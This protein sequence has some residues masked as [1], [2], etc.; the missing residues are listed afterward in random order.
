MQTDSPILV[1]GS[2]GK[3]GRRVAEQLRQQ[4]LAVRE[5]SRQSEIPFD[6]A[7]PATW[8][9]S[10]RGVWAAYIT[11]FPD[12]AEPAAPA[13]IRE[14]TALA[15]A[16]GLERLVLLSGRGEANAE[17]CEQIVLNSGVSA[18]CVRASWFN[19]NFDEGMLI[20]SVLSGT[21]AFPAGDVRE[22]F[23]DSDDIAD[24]VVA[25]L[26]EDGHVG[27]LYEITGPRLM[28]FAEVADELARVTGRAVQYLPVSFDDFHA[29]LSREAGPEM[30]DTVTELCREVLDGRNAW[31]GDGVQRALSREPR[32]FSDYA[33]RAAA[34]GV[35]DEVPA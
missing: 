11:Y 30:A 3:T 35:W 8:A 13:K 27:Q 31:L 22:P 19:Q 24:V 9:P 6:W 28:S 15:K 32:D 18:T 33:Q 21:M 20:G 25:A 17:V 23:I 29:R 4:G 12:L 1:I 14:L 7:E 26:A 2:T 34:T 5:G 10:L 16:A